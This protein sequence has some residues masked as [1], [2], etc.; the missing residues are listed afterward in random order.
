MRG[1]P[2]VSVEIPFVLSGSGISTTGTI[3]DLS[4]SGA[5]D[6]IGERRV[7]GR[8]AREVG[9]SARRALGGGG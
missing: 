5:R 6:G 3:I 1:L 4:L 7:P 9:L 8:F 2:R